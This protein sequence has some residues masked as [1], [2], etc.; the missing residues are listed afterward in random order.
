MDISIGLL[1]DSY[2]GRNAG[3]IDTGDTSDG[4][5]PSTNPTDIS[6]GQSPSVNSADVSDGGSP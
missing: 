1:V 3:I 6:D 4:L 2:P 5:N